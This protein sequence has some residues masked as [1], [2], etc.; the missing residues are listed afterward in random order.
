MEM[1]YQK[2]SAKKLDETGVEPMTSPMLRE[3]ATNYATRPEDVFS[4]A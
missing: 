4:W 1:A 2:I 3:R